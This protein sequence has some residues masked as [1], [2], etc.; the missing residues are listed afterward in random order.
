MKKIVLFVL[1]LMCAD[2]GYAQNTAAMDWDTYRTKYMDIITGYDYIFHGSKISPDTI[3]YYCYIKKEGRSVLA[4]FENM[5]LVKETAFDSLELFDIVNQNLAALKKIRNNYR[6][7]YKKDR[8]PENQLGIRFMGLH[9]NHY[10]KKDAAFI[11]GLKNQQLKE[12]F[13]A[14]NLLIAIMEKK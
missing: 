7:F 14:I 10:G 2:L 3:K 1:M 9:F 11:N 8:M 13:T 12:A 5:V 4:Y 6:R